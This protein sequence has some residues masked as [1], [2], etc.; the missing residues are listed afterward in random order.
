MNMGLGA[1]ILAG[2]FHYMTQGPNEVK[3]EEE[4]KQ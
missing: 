1:A 3:E 4:E 2:I